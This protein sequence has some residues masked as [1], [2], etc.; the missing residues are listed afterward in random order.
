M[1]LGTRK[2]SWRK[3]NCPENHYPIGEG[4]CIDE[5]LYYI[6]GQAKTVKACFDV[7]NENFSF[8]KTDSS[9]MKL[10]V[11]SS[12]TKL[13]NYKGKLIRRD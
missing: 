1:T 5:V 6:A 2:M 8:F 3:L 12:P 7:R 13:I 9:I 4:V 10:L 11:P